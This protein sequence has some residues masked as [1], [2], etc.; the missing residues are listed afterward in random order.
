MVNIFTYDNSYRKSGRGLKIFYYRNKGKRGGQK[1]MIGFIIS[2][3]VD[4]YGRPLL[5]YELMSH[6]FVTLFP[7]S[8]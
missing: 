4:Q 2:E 3:N 7:L 6:N 1:V 8:L 5:S